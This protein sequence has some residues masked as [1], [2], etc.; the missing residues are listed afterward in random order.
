M[1]RNYH[2]GGQ[3]GWGGRGGGGKCKFCAGVSETEQTHDRSSCRLFKQ[4]KAATSQDSYI[5]AKLRVNDEK[6][7]AAAGAVLVYRTPEKTT[8]VLMAREDRREGDRLNFL[9]G[10]R[11]EQKETASEVARRVLDWETG[12]KLQRKTLAA[13]ESPFLVHYG[14][15]SKYVLFFLEVKDPVDYDVPAL[16]AGIEGAKQLEWVDIEQ[17]ASNLFRRRELHD[18]AAQQAS[19]LMDPPCNLL[20][21]IHAVFDAKEEDV[22]AEVAALLASLKV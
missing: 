18:W 8:E 14:A 11:L 10:K 21:R 22:E 5:D 9:G 6:G 2:R 13:L 12:G 3:G 19:D 20:S 4:L 15:E 7:F 17:L 1:R 16:S